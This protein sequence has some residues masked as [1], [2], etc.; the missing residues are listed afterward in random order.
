[1]N[2]PWITQV[3][4]ELVR[5]GLITADQAERIR[6]RYAADP[7][8]SGNRMLLVFA[9]LGSLLVGLGIILIIAHNWDEGF[10]LACLAIG[11]AG[12]SAVAG[13]GLGSTAQ[14]I[15]FSVL[16]LISFFT[17]RP[18]LMKRMWK[19]TGVRTNVDALAGQRGRVTQ[20]FDP[21]LRLGRVAVGGDDWR[22]ETTTDQPLREGDLVE[23]VSVES[24]TLIVRPIA[25]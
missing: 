24:N 23:V 6:A 13:L 12:A 15:A 1:M 9:I 10:F 4:P 8:R 5:E 22:A 14:L 20:T 25:P 18:I 2:G 16:S 17:L 19:D 3:L 11:C 21:G 7:Q